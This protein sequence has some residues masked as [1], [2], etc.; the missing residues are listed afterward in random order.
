MRTTNFEHMDPKR[1]KFKGVC[2]I[3]IHKSWGANRSHPYEICAYYRLYIYIYKFKFSTIAL[4]DFQGSKCRLIEP[5][6]DIRQALLH[7]ACR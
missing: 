5:L 3:L 2:F 1:C 6:R 4:F 7:A